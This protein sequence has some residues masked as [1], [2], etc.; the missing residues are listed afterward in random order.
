MTCREGKGDFILISPR[1]M[2]PTH[3]MKSTHKFNGRKGVED[4]VLEFPLR[5][6]QSNI[7]NE[8]FLTRV[9]KPRPP[10]ETTA[11]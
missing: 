4:E 6:M 2:L 11:T 10:L 1:L 7:G 5:I 9:L 8:R 3:E